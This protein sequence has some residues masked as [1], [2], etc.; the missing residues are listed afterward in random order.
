MNFIMDVKSRID[1]NDKSRSLR[2]L[3]KDHIKDEFKDKLDNI[4]FEL[5]RYEIKQN[6][7]CNQI[8]LNKLKTHLINVPDT[9]GSAICFLEN[10]GKSVGHAVSMYGYN[11]VEDAFAYKDSSEQANKLTKMGNKKRYKELLLQKHEHSRIAAAWTLEAHYY[12][13][14]QN[15]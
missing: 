12:Q 2:D 4:K 5:Q 1:S 10:P 6:G 15:M 11:A 3:L 7:I 14:R 8:E 9:H 13:T